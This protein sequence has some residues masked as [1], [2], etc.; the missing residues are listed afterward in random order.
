MCEPASAENSALVPVPASVP[1]L[2]PEEIHRLLLRVHRHQSE[3]Q[4]RFI[5]GLLALDEGRLYL[6]L[7]YSSTR[8]YAEKH[9]GMGRTATHEALRVARAL[10]DLPAT[11]QAFVNGLAY[12]RVLEITRVAT[13][14]KE[15][16]WIDFANR[17]SQKQ[18]QLEVQDAKA[19][20]RDHPRED[21]HYGLP[22]IRMRL[23]VELAPEEYELV[24]NALKKVK[25]ELAGSLGGG[26]VETKAALLFMAKR[27]LETDPAGTLE[28]RIEK[29]ESI[30]TI[31]YHRCLDCHRDHVLTGEGA[32][33]VPSAVVDAVEPS[34]RKEIIDPEEEIPRGTSEGEVPPAGGKNPYLEIDRPNSQGFCRRLLLRDGSTC[35]NP[36]CGRK[37]HLQGHHVVPR[38]KGG[39]T[40]FHNEVAVC[41][42][43]HSLIETGYLKVEGDALQGFAWTTS[44]DGMARDL[45]GEAVEIS[46]IPVVKAEFRYLNSGAEARV[47]RAAPAAAETRLVADCVAAL[48]KLGLTREAAVRGTRQGL[49]RLRSEGKPVEIEPLFK[50]ACRYGA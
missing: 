36:R 35:A 5:Q 49:D 43:C 19:K 25:K 22:A 44:A 2:S 33:A 10:A 45:A 23:S 26:D 16:L 46:R 27:F 20:G 47:A 37:L 9:F 14:E 32:I 17:H 21:N 50:L 34:A 7:G 3:L 41:V 1:T 38:R 15:S 40:A 12:T 6:A 24:A 48:R 39:R 11:T 8:Q 18:L 4:W 28:G 30:Y 29:E 42:T 31:L 13:P